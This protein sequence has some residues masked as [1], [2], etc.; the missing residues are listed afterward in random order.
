MFGDPEGPLIYIIVVLLLLFSAFFAGSESAY[1]YCNRH[2]MIVMADDGSKRAK[3]VLKI[4]DRYDST[5]ITTLIA[6]NICHVVTSV[7][8]TIIAIYLIGAAGSLVATII[9]TI[10]VFLFSEILPKNIAT[11][12]A[13]KWAM[14]ASFILY[15]FKI[16]FFPLTFIFNTLLKGT[17]KAFNL[18][19]DEDVFDEE[20][21]SDVVEKV[22]E[23]G[24]LD[25]EESEI[26]QAAIEFGDIKVREVYTPR[27][28]IV[29]LDYDKCNPSYLKKFILENT[30]S[31]IPVYQGSIDN[32]IGIL[33]VRTYL[34]AL[35][36]NKKVNLKDILI[37]PYYVAPTLA[38]D[39][40]FAG[41]SEF[42]T[43]IAIVRN[44]KG[45]TIGMVTMKDILEELVED[46]NEE[47]D[48]ERLVQGGESNA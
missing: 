12:N 38:I 44:K 8:T 14:N 26:I 4:L 34:K 31:R 13:D 32:I 45:K 24:I 39:E 15:F 25:E 6:I 42:K 47:S 29:A 37:E 7:L 19:E 11:L 40:I 28:K 17:K 20:D 36:L 3:L 1:A 46:I 35:F 23:E 5:I 2:R 33:H 41:F 16:L 30:Y 22:E 10:V 43:H 9:T 27:E 48:D 18:E 21:F